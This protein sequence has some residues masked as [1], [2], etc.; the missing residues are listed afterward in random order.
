MHKFENGSVQEYYDIRY[1]EEFSYTEFGVF[2]D[3]IFSSLNGLETPGLVSSPSELLE[4]D[5]WY[6]SRGHQLEG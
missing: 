1:S 2:R 3:R 5:L 4:R 6:I